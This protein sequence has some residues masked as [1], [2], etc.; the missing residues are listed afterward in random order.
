MKWTSSSPHQR[1]PKNGPPPPGKEPFG[2]L[3]GKKFKLLAGL[4]LVPVF[5]NWL[6]VGDDLNHHNPTDLAKKFGDCF[7]LRIGQRNLV[8]A[9]KGNGD[10]VLNIW[11]YQGKGVDGVLGIGFQA[12]DRVPDERDDSHGIK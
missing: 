2:S 10:M 8:R 7:L 6:Q 3:R 12:L 1:S 5:G 9:R 11:I 4:I